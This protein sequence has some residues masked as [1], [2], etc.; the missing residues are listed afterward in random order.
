LLTL[1]INPKPLLGNDTIINICQGNSFNLTAV[2]NTGSNTNSWTN[3]GVAVTN[4]A[5]IS[6]S[7]NYQL[8]S[9]NASGCTDTAFVLLNVKANPTIVINNPLPLCVPATADITAAAITSGSSAELSFTYWRDA[10]ATIVFNN[11]AAAGNGQ[12][13]IK[14]TT[15]FGCTDVK[16][17]SISSY[18]IQ[19]V[20]VGNDIGICDKDSVATLRAVVTNS[21]VPVNYQWEPAVSGNIQNPTA[22]VTMVKPITTPQQYILTTTD[23]YGC[24]YKISDTVLV[25][26]QPP[27]PAFAGNDTIAVTGLPHQL[28][29]T[30]GVGYT[31]SPSSLLNN[32]GIQNPQAVITTDSVL[33]TVIVE[34]EKGCKGYDS[35]KIKSY[36]G[37][38][39]YVPNAFSPNG[40]GVNDVFRPIPVGIVSTDLFR[41][42]NRYGQVVFETTQWMKGWDGNYKGIPQ[43]PGN[44]VWVLKGKGRNGR[45]IEMKG[46]VVLV[47]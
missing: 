43:L 32:G 20:S 10:A 27:V 41:I 14:G 13:F 42:F 29:A 12:Y 26:K 33:F 40:D 8:I 1:T 19:R 15:V 2:F 24:N 6:I 34:D 18:P 37:I 11:P 38:T 25:T 5:S 16:P 21:T 45:V 46:N 22:A 47:R 36:S 4:P 44:F 9:T 35:V 3:A 30:G 31:W 23:G 28:F 7:G 17:I 39:Y